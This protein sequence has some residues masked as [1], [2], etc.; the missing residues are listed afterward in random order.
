[1]DNETDLKYN[2]QEKNLGISK[3]RMALAGCSILKKKTKL[4]IVNNNSKNTN[5]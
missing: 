3:N 5:G 1:M 2:K 4:K